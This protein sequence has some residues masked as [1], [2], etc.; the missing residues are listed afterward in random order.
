MSER[1][2]IDLARGSK[3]DLMGTHNRVMRTGPGCF[4][5]LIAVDPEA[6]RPS[7]TRWF[8]LD[9]PETAARLDERARALT[10][11][12]RTDDL[13]G[14]IAR[15]PIDLGEILHFTRGDRTWRLTVPADGSLPGGGLLPGFI[16]W[17]P[18]PHPSEAQD[19]L[20]VRLTSI[21]L[22]HPRPHELSA[23]LRALS[24]DQLAAV[25]EGE[26]GLAFEL[27][28]PRGRIVID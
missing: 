8:S 19:D 21:R 22:S 3:H 20:G 13:E 9:D 14:T 5:E 23:T 25:A 27:E 10:W 18:G 15:S 26:P 11:V 12:V 2:G 24:V 6:P 17:S 1:L 28:M 16:E 7:R 4:F